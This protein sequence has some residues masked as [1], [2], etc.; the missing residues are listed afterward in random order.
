MTP[1]PTTAAPGVA[2][3]A[4]ALADAACEL[5]DAASSPGSWTA[6]AAEEAVE[7]M[8][9]TALALHGAHPAAAAAMD[10]VAQ[11]LARLR[12][13]LDLTAADEDDAQDQIVTPPTPIRR[14][15]RRGLG[16]GYR[17]LRVPPGPAAS[18]Q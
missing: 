13:D 1:F 14:R 8:E 3:R 7:A 6:A 16:P 17:G 5:H 11:V 10:T 18:G 9:T 2:D 12:R 4:E 15:T